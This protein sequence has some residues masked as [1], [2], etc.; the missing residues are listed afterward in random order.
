M[1]RKALSTTMDEDLLRALKVAAARF[2]RPLNQLPE[3]GARK[4]LE[5]LWQ[6][7]PD[8]ALFAERQHEPEEDLLAEIESRLKR[9]RGNGESAS[10]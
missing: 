1:G 5:E 7:N 8:A 4:I 10:V 6:P 3:E 9:V 2:D